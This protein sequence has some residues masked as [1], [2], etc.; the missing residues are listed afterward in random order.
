MKNNSSKNTWITI[1]IIIAVSVGIY[2][3]F[4]K[5]PAVPENTSFE[6]QPEGELVG[7]QVLA[8]LNQIESLRIDNTLFQSPAYQSL[9]DYTVPIPVLNVGRANPFA[10][11]PGYVPK[12]KN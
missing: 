8:L 6:V 5:D 1:A 10:P 9:V 2:Y 11:I 12:K 4:M 7:A 3:F